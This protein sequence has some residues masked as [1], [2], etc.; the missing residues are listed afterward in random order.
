MAFGKSVPTKGDNRPCHGRHKLWDKE[1]AS[2]LSVEVVALHNSK[3]VAP[4]L[5]F[6]VPLSRSNMGCIGISL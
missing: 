5:K 3:T 1:Y 6:I 2:G 4:F